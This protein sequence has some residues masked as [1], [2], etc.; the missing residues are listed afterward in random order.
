MTCARW[1]LL[2]LLG[3]A[4][5]QSKFVSAP[6]PVEIDAR[7][8]HR[9]FDASIL[10]LREEGFAIDRQDHR[11]GRITTK[12]LSSPTV[13]EPWRTTNTTAHQTAE[14]TFNNDRRIVTVMLEPEPSTT[15]SNVPASPLVARP[16]TPL[17][18]EESVAT[19]AVMP[20][21]PSAYRLR[22]EVMVERFS[23]PVRYLNG[24]TRGEQIVSRL[25]TTPTELSQRGIDRNYWE[26]A[27]RDVYLESR[28]IAGIVRRSVTL[29]DSRRPDDTSTQTT[30][31]TMPTTVPSVQPEIPSPAA[32]EGLE[33]R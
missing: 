31:T 27:G 16:S 24:S 14:S 15:E 8:Y 9:M 11:F 2:L 21:S 32:T 29:P 19:D 33:G 25:R 13:F 6:N 7:E 17:G 10:T 30:A 18:A 3:L 12:P 20:P 26:S 4:G 5:C 23:A 1:S 22:V 28:L